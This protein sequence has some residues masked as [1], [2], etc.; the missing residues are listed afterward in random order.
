MYKIND[1]W[2]ENRKSRTHTHTCTQDEEKNQTHAHMLRQSDTNDLIKR[3]IEI[4]IQIIK[5]E[6]NIHYANDIRAY[7]AYFFAFIQ[8][9]A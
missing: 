6:I 3:K 1:E 5:N 2:G 4:T 7:P 8:I 9:Q